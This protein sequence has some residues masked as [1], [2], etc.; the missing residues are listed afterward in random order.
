MGI[1]LLHCY[2]WG[3]L[4]AN[5]LQVSIGS[6][7]N[8]YSRMCGFVSL[9]WEIAW[10]LG[11][12]SGTQSR[13]PF[14]PPTLRSAAS[15]WKQEGTQGGMC[16]MAPDTFLDQ[17]QV[18]HGCYI[19]HACYY[20]SPGHDYYVNDARFFDLVQVYRGYCRGDSCMIKN[21]QAPWDPGEFFS[22]TAWGQAVFQEGRGVSDLITTSPVIAR[23]EQG[24][25]HL[26]A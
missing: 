26:P 4:L 19:D 22:A 5:F 24:P 2:A 6:C 17:A 7:L 14:L 25:A 13:Q 12:V 9:Q 21:L 3:L 11:S 10:T 15:T 16:D 20:F 1:V 8:R 23:H 18:R